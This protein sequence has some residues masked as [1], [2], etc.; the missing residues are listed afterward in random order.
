MEGRE[1]GKEIELNRKTNSGCVERK[2]ERKTDRQ[3]TAYFVAPSL[4]FCVAF[5]CRGRK[6]SLIANSESRLSCSDRLVLSA[7]TRTRTLTSSRAREQG[8]LE[9]VA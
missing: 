7:L 3:L 5:T 9:L 1:D 8:G 6:V 4:R 2:N